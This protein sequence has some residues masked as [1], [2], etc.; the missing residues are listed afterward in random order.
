[1]SLDHPGLNVAVIR[2]RAADLGLT[3]T[4]LKRL[5]GIS[6]ADLQ[7]DP[8]PHVS[9]ALLVRL[10]RV[11]GLTLDQLVGA[12]AGEPPTPGDGDGAPADAADAAVVLAALA[13]YGEFA[14]DDLAAALRWTRARLAAAVGALKSGELDGQ[15]AATTLATAFRT[16]LWVAVTDQAVALTQAPGGLPREVRARIEAELVRRVPLDPYEAGHLLRLVRDKLLEAFPEDPEFAAAPLFAGLIE[17][18]VRRG[19]A[20]PAPSAPIG[21]A[22]TDT[23]V[24][25]LVDAHP[26]VM[27]ALRLAEEPAVDPSG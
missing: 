27:F 7:R 4:R 17:R 21:E 3:D 25:G 8:H 19:I 10:S 14:L 2:A 13:A 24:G 22:D 26:D 1:M 5:T 15:L 6:L 18:L 11:L 20:V 23:D 12:G 9:V 16:A